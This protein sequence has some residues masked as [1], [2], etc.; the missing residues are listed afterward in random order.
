MRAGCALCARVTSANAAR[1]AREAVR[2]VGMAGRCASIAA[3]VKR[4]AACA[5]DVSHLMRIG[6]VPDGRP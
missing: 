1:N 6:E 2:T 4:R 3:D 5:C